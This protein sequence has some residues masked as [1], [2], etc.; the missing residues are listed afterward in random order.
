SRAAGGRAGPATEDGEL[1]SMTNEDVVAQL[2]VVGASA[3]GVEALSVL[4]STLPAGFSV[5]IVVAQHLDPQR[6]S[7]LGEILAR[8]SALPVRTVTS[9]EHLEPGVVYVVPADR[10]V[11][12]TDGD[13]RVVPDGAA[14]RARGR[15]RVAAEGD[16]LGEPGGTA[17]G[18]PPG[19]PAE[20]S[21]GP[22]PSIDRLLRS[23]AAAY[24]EG[25]IAVI[26]TGSG[27]DGA[28]GAHDVREAGG[29][30]IIQN[31]ATARFPA[32][33]Q[34]LAPTTVDFVAELEAIGPL[35]QEL[36]AG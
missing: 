18:S 5:P 19:P 35:L 2:V 20:R 14:A 6:P 27:A 11:E 31:P 16:G 32:M 24:G 33:P 4:V 9:Q 22:A 21:T 15:R 8:R 25:L 30:V 12:V 7:H 23:A 10:H 36:V 29:T 17:A 28:S 26:L 34:S 3:G 13:V 1:G